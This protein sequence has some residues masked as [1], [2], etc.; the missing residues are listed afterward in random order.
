MSTTAFKARGRKLAASASA[1]AVATT[2]GATLLGAPAQ[3]SPNDDHHR[4]HSHGYGVVIARHGLN[5][6]MDPSRDSARRGW[7]HRHEHV[8]LRC[9]V[10][11]QWIRGDVRWFQLRRRHGGDGYGYDD[12]FGRGGGRF[13]RDGGRFGR[14]GGRDGGRFGRDG[15]RFGRDGGRF[16]RDEGR[17]GG[18]RWDRWDRGRRHWVSGRYLRVRGHVPLCKFVERGRFRST[19]K[20]RRGE[21]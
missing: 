20:M 10:R 21:G 13:G 2:L 7:L 3:A 9:R 19:A 15:G 14:D 11:A 17:F 4:R 12:G 6:R 8:R 16:G 1:L 18:Y 5:V